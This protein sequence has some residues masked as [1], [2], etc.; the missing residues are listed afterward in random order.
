MIFLT[1]LYTFVKSG[2]IVCLIQDASSGQLMICLVTYQE[3]VTPQDEATVKPNLFLFG[4][5]GAKSN[6]L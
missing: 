3:L 1:G 2:N 5:F 4:I 6:I